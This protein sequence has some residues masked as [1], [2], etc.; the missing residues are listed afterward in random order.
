MLHVAGTSCIA[1][2][3][4][5]SQKGVRDA[6]IVPFLAWCALRIALQEPLVLHENST[7]FPIAVLRRL[8]GH[9]YH[10][11]DTDVEALHYG[12]TVRR[13]R[14]LTRMVH[15]TKAS[16]LCNPGF[17]RFNERF[18]RECIMHWKAYYWQHL[19]DDPIAKAVFKCSNTA[20]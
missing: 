6:S 15:K 17:S 7:R 14:K 19:V 13:E 12:G 3:P 1:F 18:H 8:L 5:G 4:N 16:I 9:I 2:A 11:D 10:I 20:L